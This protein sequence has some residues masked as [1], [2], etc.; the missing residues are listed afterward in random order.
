MVHTLPPWTTKYRMV[1]VFG[2]IDSG[3]LAARLGGLSRFDRRG[4][5]IWYD[6]FN[7]NLAKWLATSSGAGASTVLSIERPYFHD[8]SCKL[9]GGSTLSKYARLLG[10]WPEFHSTRVGAEWIFSYKENGDYFELVLDCNST[11]TG[12]YGI[13][14][15]DI[16]NKEIQYYDTDVADYVK[17][18]DLTLLEDERMFTS[19][20]LVIDRATGKYVRC[21]LPWIEY[22]LSSHDLVS[23]GGG[24]SPTTFSRFGIWSSGAT[25]AVAYAGGFILT[26]NEP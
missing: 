24:A 6:D 9:V 25:N 20:K 14:R 21:I 10:R 3:E 11:V 1:K 13:I 18:D 22:D 2:Q 12:Y 5:V 16:T 17:I 23:Y 8:S 26:H 15:I 19:L 7:E 4:A